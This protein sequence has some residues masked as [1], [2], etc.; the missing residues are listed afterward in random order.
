MGKVRKIDRNQMLGKLCH[1]LF[2]KLPTQAVQN[3]APNFWNWF[4]VYYS[5][6]SLVED[7]SSIQGTCSAAHNKIHCGLKFFIHRR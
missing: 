2:T 3:L 4:V 7:A 6:L 1:E 5:D